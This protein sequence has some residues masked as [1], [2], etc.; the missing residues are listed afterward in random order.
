MGRLETEPGDKCSCVMS[1]LPGLGW[2]TVNMHLFL[3]KAASRLANKLNSLSCSAACH[4]LCVPPLTEWN[5]DI[6]DRY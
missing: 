4:Y 1:F 3:P 5:S 6:G 2:R